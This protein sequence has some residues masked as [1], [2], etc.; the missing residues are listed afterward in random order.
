MHLNLNYS[1]DSWRPILKSPRAPKSSVIVYIVYV[2]QLMVT[3]I[4]NLHQKYVSFTFLAVCFDDR[5]LGG[6][7]TVKMALSIYLA[8]LCSLIPSLG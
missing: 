7:T 8:K 3:Y 2:C 5:N 6:V 4:N 1:V